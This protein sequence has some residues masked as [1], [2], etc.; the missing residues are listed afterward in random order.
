MQ[1]RPFVPEIRAAGAEPF[2]IGNGSPEQADWFSTRFDPG[3][4]VYTDPELAVYRALGARN[5][6][7]G[8]LHPRSLIAMYRA[9]R[10]GSRAAGLQGSASQL[11]GVFLIT[12]EGGMPFA[13]RAA[14]NGEH[15]SPET[16]LSALHEHLR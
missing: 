9:R 8:T 12:P 1:L 10:H 16:I 15:P 6:W 2:I 3:M 7:L 14:R 5:S 13:F 11:G 4:P